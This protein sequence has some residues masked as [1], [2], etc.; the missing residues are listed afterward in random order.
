[1]K[2]VHEIAL[3]AIRFRATFPPPRGT[4]HKPTQ[5]NYEYY[6]AKNNHHQQSQNHL[7]HAAQN[8]DG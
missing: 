6:H 3:H 1:M 2:K 7:L 8:M 5:E 4:E